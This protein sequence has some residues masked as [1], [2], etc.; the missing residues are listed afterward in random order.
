MSS[1]SDLAQESIFQKHVY[2]SSYNPRYYHSRE[3]NKN[4]A[5]KV[6]DLTQGPWEMLLG[7]GNQTPDA[8]SP[9]AFLR[10]GHPPRGW[11]FPLEAGDQQGAP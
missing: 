5:P 9:V 3:T 2:L 10:T 1:T 6:K 4:K 11:L 7:N 8:L